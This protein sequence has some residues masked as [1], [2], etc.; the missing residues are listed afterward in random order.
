MR[1]QPSAKAAF[2]PASSSSSVTSLLMTPRSRSVPASGATVSP[3]L[4]TRE[5]ASGSSASWSLMRRLE[6]ES[7]TPSG[8]AK[9]FM[10]SSSSPKPG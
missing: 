2:A 5:S 9:A 6:S 8:S 10:R 3:L 1:R 4:R 7:P